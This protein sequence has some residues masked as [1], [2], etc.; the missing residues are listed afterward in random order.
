[1]E[2][3]EVNR[4][5]ST[6]AISLYGNGVIA[7]IIDTGIDYTNPLFLNADGSSRIVAIWDQ[8]IESNNASDG[9]D[10]GTVYN[11]DRI[12]E[13]LRSENPY[14]IVPSRDEEGHGTF[15]AGI[16]AGGID[17]ENDFYGVAPNADILVIKLKNAKTI[18]RNF[19]EI[20]EGVL[21]FQENDIINGINY[22]SMYA[23]GA[24][25]PVSMC[26]GLG[27][28][29]GGHTGL[30]F[31]DKFVERVGSAKERCISVAAGNEGNARHHYE[32][33]IEDGTDVMEI[34]VAQEENGFV[35]EVWGEAPSVFAVGI[36][37][38]IGG[39]IDRIPPRFENIDRVELFLEG[40]KIEVYYKL[41]E[42]QSGNEVIHIFFN[43]IPILL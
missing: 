4:V 10:Y 40:T 38:H 20:P 11:R 35:L 15:M 9:V 34:N 5:R 13:A 22:A 43:L 36:E 37:S 17:E 39:K 19:Y 33:T 18:L 23:T 25:Q 28:N 2:E 27:S 16:V 30:G 21:A 7:A 6:P 32:G 12:N 24:R 26:V 42:E 8:S 29:S 3:I 31:L 14:D 41:I 1:M